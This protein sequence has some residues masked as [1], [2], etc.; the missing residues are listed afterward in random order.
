MARSLRLSFENAF[1]HI[2][3]RGIRKENIFYSDRDKY[4]FID[5]MNETFVEQN[6]IFKK[7]KAIFTEN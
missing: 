2:T 4:V 5:K 7:A 6:I 3:A 1:Y